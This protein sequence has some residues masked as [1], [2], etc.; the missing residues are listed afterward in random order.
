MM[1]RQ[2]VGNFS[3]LVLLATACTAP[4]ADSRPT[5]ELRLVAVDSVD[6]VDV[7]A[8]EPMVVRHPSGTL[9]VSGYGDSIPHLWKST[10]NGATWT[11]VN[12]GTTADGAAGNSDVDLAVAPEGTLYFF[13]MVFDRTKLEGVKVQVAVSRDTGATWSWTALSS[14][15]FDDRP[16]V[17]VAPDGTAHAI[18]NDGAGVSHA[19]SV[20]GGRTWVE[21]D[22]INPLGGSSHLA[23]GPRGEV[24]VRV[25]PLSASGN[26]FDAGVELVA[27]S[28]D[29]GR[30]WQR[31]TPP[32]DREWRPFVD[33]TVT[34]ARWEMPPQPRWVEP[35][36]WDASGALYSFWA[37]GP[38][39]WLARST[40]R[41]ATWTTWPVA[42]GDDVAYFPY[43]VARG[44]GELAA[45]WFSGKGDSLRAHVA[46]IDVPSDGG[47]PR[48]AL[49]AP[50]QPESWGLPMGPNQNLERDSA[51][52]YLALTFLRDATIGVVAP[53]QNPAGKR[54][55]FSWRRY[56]LHR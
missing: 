17:E 39:L 20:D 51:G 47:A 46:R 40:D 52:E 49:A 32:G 12:V 30:T 16:W 29:G 33:T 19:V 45:S 22:R 48:V 13:T 5:A 25:V 27:V 53:I 7:L 4:A 1:R 42:E 43:L 37:S 2:A 55:G 54:M 56:A 28:T 31:H 24:A 50:F 44:A 11:P 41:G 35:L 23:V 3:G 34:P 6:H 15:R 10:D 18:W 26:R 8:R 21:R 9:F 14:T 38:S 36:A